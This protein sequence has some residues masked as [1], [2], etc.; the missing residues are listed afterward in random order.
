MVLPEIISFSFG[1]SDSPNI[2]KVEPLFDL[3]C[4][5]YSVFFQNWVT[6]LRIKKRIKNY[7]EITAENYILI[8]NI[9]DAVDNFA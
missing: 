2:N 8:L 3:N 6:P 4:F 5:C 7:I 9:I 1:I